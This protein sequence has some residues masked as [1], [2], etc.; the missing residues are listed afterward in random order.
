MFFFGKAASVFAGAA[1]LAV[2][3]V[4]SATPVNFV[5]PDGWSVGD[6]GSTYQAWDV[7]TSTLGN[8]PDVGYDNGGSSVVPSGVGVS[9]PYVASSGNFYGLFGDFG[10]TAD[11]VNA[12]DSSGSGTHIVVQLASTMTADDVQVLD[13]QGGVIAGVSELR[14]DSLGQ[15]FLY[16]MTPP[17]STT[18]VPIYSYEE[19]YEF[20]VPN[21][22]G[23]FQIVASYGAHSSFDGLR[24]DSYLSDSAM[25]VTA[26]PEPAAFS[27]ILL[28]SMMLLKRKK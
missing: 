21:Y 25:A 1:V 6:I 22:T 3:G 24:I 13:D 8:V 18:P 17:G 9:G 7:F 4:A 16:N 10:V 19:I 5:N 27:L 12:T 11:V 28:G 15:V 2:A 20:Y 26:I 23:D 14:A